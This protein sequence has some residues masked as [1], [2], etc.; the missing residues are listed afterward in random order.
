[1]MS[2]YITRSSR[3]IALITA[4]PSAGAGLLALSSLIAQ[5]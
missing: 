4:G 3:P 2:P 5:L 1:M